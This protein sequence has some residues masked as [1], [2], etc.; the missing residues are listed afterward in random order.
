V[1]IRAPTDSQQSVEQ[2]ATAMI[3]QFFF[4]VISTLTAGGLR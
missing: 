3:R 1:K 4:F 2:I